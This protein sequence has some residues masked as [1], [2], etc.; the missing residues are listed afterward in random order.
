LK[1]GYEIAQ[2]KTQAAYYLD[3]SIT[4]GLVVTDLASEGGGPS[5]RP[6]R[7]LDQ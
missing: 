1:H 3:F 7:L 6:E 4:R 5:K 2:D